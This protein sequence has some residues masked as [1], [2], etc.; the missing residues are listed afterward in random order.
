MCVCVGGMGLP[1]TLWG[2]PECGVGVPTAYSRPDVTV[3]EPRASQCLMKRAFKAYYQNS[4]ASK[5]LE[6]RRKGSREQTETSGNI[7]R[8]LRRK[9][10]VPAESHRPSEELTKVGDPAGART[11]SLALAVTSFISNGRVPS[12]SASAELQ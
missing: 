8:A 7:L 1:S 3:N 9:S 11:E 6:R 12:V 4:D 2:Q 5:E 10:H